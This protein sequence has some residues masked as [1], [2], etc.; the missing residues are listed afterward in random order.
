MDESIYPRATEFNP[1][2]FSRMREQN[3]G[4]EDVAPKY[5]V[6]SL[7]ATH[8]PFGHGKHVWW[9]PPSLK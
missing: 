2:R 3:L 7:G 6:V 5:T 4:S 9:V 1:F 8:V